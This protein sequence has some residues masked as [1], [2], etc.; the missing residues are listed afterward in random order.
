M[1]GESYRSRAW[2]GVTLKQFRAYPGTLY[3][4]LADVRLP[5]ILLPQHPECWDYKRDPTRLASVGFIF[6]VVLFG[7]GFV[8]PI[9]ASLL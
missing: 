7:E 9:L 4:A 2:E 5:N 8:T 6:V 1:R 3:V